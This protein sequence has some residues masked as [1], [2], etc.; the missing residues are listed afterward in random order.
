ML[1]LWISHLSRFIFILSSPGFPLVMEAPRMPSAIPRYG[2]LARTC[3]SAQ[4]RHIVARTAGSGIIL[5]PDKPGILHKRRLPWIRDTVRVIPPPLDPMAK[6]ENEKKKD[7][8]SQAATNVRDLFRWKTCVL[9]Y[10][11]SGNQTEEWQSPEPRKSLCLFKIFC[12]T[13]TFLSPESCE[14]ICKAYA[15]ELVVLPRWSSSL[16]R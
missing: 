9:V 13:Q 5:S 11:A 7:L 8:L 10:D 12:L 1:A 14:V 2:V 16:D 6:L 3:C 4:I 15:Y